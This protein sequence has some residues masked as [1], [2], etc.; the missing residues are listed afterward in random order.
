MAVPD[1]QRDAWNAGASGA[2]RPGAR[3]AGE[4]ASL[5]RALP[6]TV[7]TQVEGLLDRVAARAVTAPLAVRTVEDAREHL[8][9]T[10]GGAAG[11]V[12]WAAALAGRTRKTLSWRGRAIPLSMAAKLGGEVVNS[13]RLGAYELEVLASLL[14]NR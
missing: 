1:E 2:E 11:A 8:Q 12:S 3:N 6:G 13:F 4:L 14:V 5:A 9:Q 10:P 7:V